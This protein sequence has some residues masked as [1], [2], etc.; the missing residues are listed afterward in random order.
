MVKMTYVTKHQLVITF[1]G[2][3]NDK[4]KGTSI[5]FKQIALYTL[6]TLQPMWWYSHCC[7]CSCTN[8]WSIATKSQNYSFLFPCSPLRYSAV[9]LL[10]LSLQLWWRQCYRNVSQSRQSFI[11]NSN[12]HGRDQGEH[13][14]PCTSL[15]SLLE[16][17]SMIKIKLQC[18]L[19]LCY[20]AT[21]HVTILHALPPL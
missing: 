3:I 12:Q 15:S 17:S 18:T 2:K 8:R 13:M 16:E 21:A 10:H 1:R 7:Q 9:A 5:F 19:T 20:T 6:T 4:N 14:W 11:D